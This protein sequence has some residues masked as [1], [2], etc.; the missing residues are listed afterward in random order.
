[1]GQSESLPVKISSNGTEELELKGY[2]VHLGRCALACLAVVLTLGLL[3][4]LLVWRKDI[5]MWMFYKECPLQHAS[6]VL[7]KVVHSGEHGY[8][9]AGTFHF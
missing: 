4:I 3:L 7:V 2:R 1:M 8:L 6:K 9:C 5:K